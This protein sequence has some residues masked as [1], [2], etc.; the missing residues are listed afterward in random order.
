MNI[1]SRHKTLTCFE[2][3]SLHNEYRVMNFLASR[4]ASRKPSATS[5]I[6]QISSKSG[7]TIA[8]GLLGKN[9]SGMITDT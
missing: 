7:T 6:S 4:R 8:H 2:S 5:I 1:T 9:T 3:N